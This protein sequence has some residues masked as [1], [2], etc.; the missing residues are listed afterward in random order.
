MGP[1]KWNNDKL[2]VLKSLEIFIILKFVKVSQIYLNSIKNIVF[3]GKQN[4][5]Y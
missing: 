5:N 1:Q 3:Q 2:N 4:L